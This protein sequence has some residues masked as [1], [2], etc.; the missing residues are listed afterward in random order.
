LTQAEKSISPLFRPQKPLLLLLSQLPRVVFLEGLIGLVALLEHPGEQVSVVP[1]PNAPGM[2]ATAASSAVCPSSTSSGKNIIVGVNSAPQRRTACPFRQRLAVEI[3]HD[4]D[5]A[6]HVD[7][8][9]EEILSSMKLRD[10]GRG[11]T[12]S[13]ILVQ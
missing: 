1:A 8:H 3:G 13:C 6:E 12:S 10:L 2:T 4:L 9:D 7:L 11:N 5:I